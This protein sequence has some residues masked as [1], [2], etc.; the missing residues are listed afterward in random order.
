MSDPTTSTAA[1]APPRGLL[2]YLHSLAESQ[3]GQ[4][5]MVLLV[6]AAGAVGGL[7]A[8][9]LE[10]TTGGQLFPKLSTFLAICAAML[11]GG[12]A[13]GI[14]VYLLAKTDLRQFGSALFFALLCGIFFK[15]VL[16]AG[17]DFVV[18]AVARSDAQSTEG[19]VQKSTTALSQSSTGS[20]PSKVEQDVKKVADVTGELLD[21]SA[22]VPDADARK[23]FESQ[24][25][26]AVE[27]ISTAAANSPE[28]SV[29]GLTEIGLKAE[30]NGQHQIKSQVIGSLRAIETKNPTTEA[31]R[32][33]RR[34]L[35]RLGK[36]LF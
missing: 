26:K 33:A 35:E 20:D 30:A 16:G 34:T 3:A 25:A 10:Y 6:V 19:E 4:A 24:S 8:W 28:A 2:A 27:A 7:M 1:T 32:K 31:A 14:G 36:G 13:G 23:S 9:I 12:A 21:K 5:G 22:N 11:F 17:K 15:P 29:D 18:G